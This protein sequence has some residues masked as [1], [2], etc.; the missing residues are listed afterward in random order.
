MKT[1]GKLEIPPILLQTF[2]LC[3]CAVPSLEY[4]WVAL[5]T[6]CAELRQPVIRT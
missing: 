2:A 3:A 6:S 5:E 1:S 4:E